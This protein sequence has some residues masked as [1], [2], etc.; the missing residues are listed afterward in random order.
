MDQEV[1]HKISIGPQRFEIDVNFAAGFAANICICLKLKLMWECDAWYLHILCISNYLF[2]TY[3]SAYCTLQTHWVSQ[4]AIWSRALINVIPLTTSLT[5]APP[6]DAAAFDEEWRR[7]AGRYSSNSRSLDYSR[8]RRA[9]GQQLAITAP[10][11][12]SPPAGHR[13]ESPRHRQPHTRPRYDWWEVREQ[14]RCLSCGW[15]RKLTS[16]CL[17]TLLS[18]YSF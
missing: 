11:T 12:S 13:H 4:K 14:P 8:D 6:G 9:G 18:S 5:T 16:S 17:W 1:R 15:N 2:G 3:N 10:P 7:E